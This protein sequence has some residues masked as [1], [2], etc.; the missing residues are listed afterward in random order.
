MTLDL[1]VLRSTFAAKNYLLTAHAS[2]RAA[3]RGI[4]S[5]EIESAVISGEMIED[6]P[7]D[8]YRPSC[9]I[10]GHT[11]AGRILH[12][13]VSYPP[14]VKVITVYE[15]SHDEWE[16]DFRRRTSK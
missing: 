1:V 16:S 2:N 11:P 5:I 3:S 6:Y 14:Y 4:L 10:L 15:P 7:N 13:H 9:L 12:I 8:K